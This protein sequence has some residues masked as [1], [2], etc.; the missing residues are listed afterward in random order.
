MENI[1][2]VIPT[3]PTEDTLTKSWDEKHR[4]SC[5]QEYINSCIMEVGLDH[6][7]PWHV[8]I[9]FTLVYALQFII[10]PI[11]LIISYFIKKPVKIWKYKYKNINFK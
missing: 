3:I 7:L 10:V 5:A 9:W 8:A 2:E 4:C 11:A 1:E 6:N